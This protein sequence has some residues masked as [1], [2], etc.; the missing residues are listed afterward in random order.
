RSDA[1]DLPRSFSP[2]SVISTYCHF[3]LK[4]MT[5]KLLYTLNTFIVNKAEEW[6]QRSVVMAPVLNPLGD[7]SDETAPK[8]HIWFLCLVLPPWDVHSLIVYQ[9]T[10]CHSSGICLIE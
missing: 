6:L 9:K 8:G 7:C 2:R 3:L 1:S 5:L 10:M 4:G